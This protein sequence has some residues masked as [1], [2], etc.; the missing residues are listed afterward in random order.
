VP[1]PDDFR[2]SDVSTSA[3]ETCR[4]WFYKTA[5]IR[6]LMPRFY[7]DLALS[8]SYRFLDDTD[9]GLHL[10]RLGKT[11]R[12][13][14]DPLAA[15]YARA[16]LVTK[17]NDSAASFSSTPPPPGVLP[18]SHNHALLEAFDDFMFTFK[19]LKSSHFVDVTAVQKA[20]I[21]L[22]EYI[23]L[24][25]PA[26]QWMLQN[27]GYRGSEELFFALIQQ[28]RDYCNNSIV[29]LHLLSS[30][31]PQLVSKH[32]LDMVQ[33]IKASDTNSQLPKSRLYLALGKAMMSCP[34]PEAQRLAI[35]NDVW[36]AVTKIEDP[37]EYMEIAE[38]FIQYILVNF[39]DRETNIF[40]KDVIKHVKVDQSHLRLQ[41]RLL[42]VLSKT[43]QFSKDMEKTL[44]MDHF[45]PVIDLLEKSAKVEASKSILSR[46]V[47]NGRPTADP[48]ILHTL[49]DV[50]R[51]LHD[52]VDSMSLDEDRRQI[53][54]LIIN[55]IRKIDFGRDLE[56]Q[57]NSYVDCRAA[58]TNLDA[59]TQELV[60]RVCLLA[61]RAHQ[62]MKG[63]H[64]KKTSSFVKACL[65][66]CHI[67]I[68]SL[69]DIFTRLRLLL[70]CGKVALMNQM[71]VQAEAFLRAAI[72]LLSLVPPTIESQGKKVSSE[73]ELVSFL[74]HFSS[75]LLLFPGHP[76]HG[77]FYLV[78]GFLNSLE[79]FE[80][81]K[82]QDNV[83]PSQGKI[84]VY[85][86]VLALF[87]TYAQP[88]FPYHIDRVESN[89]SLYGGDSS[90][91]A[92]VT[93]FIDTLME[94]LVA[95]LTQLSAATDL[96]ARKRQGTLCLDF[97][98]QIISSLTM[99][100]ASATLV[101]KLFQLAHQTQAVEPGYL[102]RTL[103][104]IQHK[105]GSWYQDVAAK[106]LDLGGVSMLLERPAAVPKAP[107]SVSVTPT[108]S[109]GS[110]SVS[111]ST[112]SA[113]VSPLS[114]APKPAVA[115]TA[116]VTPKASA[117]LSSASPS[118]SSSSPSSSS[119]SSAMVDP[120]MGRAF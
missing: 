51:S 94:Q 77:P 17:A 81:W 73:D 109:S 78:R 24:Y 89:D 46:F 20:K 104:H 52:S 114:P 88:T 11:I 79:N 18:A 38:V 113:V 82:Q 62:F 29:L 10:Q 70:E 58:F 87:C 74:Q 34:P 9:F 15:T 83:L 120:L 30:F 108:A 60:M 67:T 36:K 98:N 7:I 101:V 2:A 90:Y 100:N 3:K 6:E 95:M 27:I 93:L 64:S 115:A 44:S 54:N 1:L 42:S 31:R 28:Y 41:E 23:D 50:A 37:T 14:G 119:S 21:A 32:A 99:N 92:Q 63:K 91:M 106:I 48:L 49:M 97:V 45:L 85:M 33:L 80:P 116:S 71:S 13:I 103:L 105:K 102:R 59:V 65:A 118:P 47:S 86:S 4:N 110:S 22:D 112:S 39:T 111:T 57:L 12:G 68:P 117:V 40:L 25:S 72:S 8:K 61:S 75:A 19:H 16:F 66:Y 84:R 69:D 107:V 96:I 43:V 5:C 35:L 26:V 76:E 56:Q 55:L 53:S